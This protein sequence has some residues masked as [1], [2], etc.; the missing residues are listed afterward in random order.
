MVWLTLITQFQSPVSALS[1]TLTEVHR[2]TGLMEIMVEVN[3]AAVQSEI[4]AE[5]N[6]AAEPPEIL[7][8]GNQAAVLLYFI[9][10]P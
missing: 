7:A 1:M 10:V 8:E 4:L 5:V 6:R 9:Q 3:T 2:A